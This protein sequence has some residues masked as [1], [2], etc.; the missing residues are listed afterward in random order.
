MGHGE[1]QRPQILLQLAEQPVHTDEREDA[2][3][4]QDADGDDHQRD[5]VGRQERHPGHTGQRNRRG[6]REIQRAA[7]V[8][9][10]QFV[11]VGT[12][13]DVLR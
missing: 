10:T 1:L 9:S 5:L 4:A 11:R 7:A 6:H 12:A 3:D 8:E 13:G 2:A